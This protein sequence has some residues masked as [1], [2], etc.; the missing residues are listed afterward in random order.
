VIPRNTSDKTTLADFI[1]CIEQP[2]GK[3]NRTW[4]MERGIPAEETPKIMRD[5]DPSG[6]YL[7]GKPIG[8]LKPAG[9]TLSDAP[10]GKRSGQRS[11]SNCWN[12]RTNARC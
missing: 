8:R 6:H 10:L 5:S 2:Y 4:V 3:V 12:R 7:V 9:P 11:K 1:E